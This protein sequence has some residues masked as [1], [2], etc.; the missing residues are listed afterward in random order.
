MSHYDNIIGMI[1]V[2][3]VL[4]AYCLL[5]IQR[6]E[7]M[8]FWYSFMNAIG[9]ALILY[10]LMQHWNLSAFAMEFSWL[11]VSLYGVIMYF[12]RRTHPAYA[13]LKQRKQRAKIQKHIHESIQ[14]LKQH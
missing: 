3:F 8:G 13:L 12:F 14:E 2:G 6:I 4:I 9:S 7:P 5:Q 10:S 1:G 11:L